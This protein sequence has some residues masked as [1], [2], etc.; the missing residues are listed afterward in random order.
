MYSSNHLYYTFVF[1]EI[2]KEMTEL[3]LAGV[4]RQP[5]YWSNLYVINF[6]L[7]TVKKINSP[8]HEQKN[9]SETFSSAEYSAYQVFSVFG[10][11]DTRLVLNILKTGNNLFLHLFEVS[12]LL[13][14]ISFSVFR[15]VLE[16][17][18]IYFTIYFR[19]L[20]ANF[21]TPKT[22]TPDHNTE[23]TTHEKLYFSS[24][25]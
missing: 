22:T 9:H 13:I 6:L 3:R 19:F 2:G 20:K 18:H 7:A 16:H 15:V 4:L 8:Y 17:Q 25:R 10:E 23:H 1:T 24:A 11:F 12:L 14:T 5:V 21:N